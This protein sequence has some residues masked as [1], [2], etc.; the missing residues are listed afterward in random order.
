MRLFLVL[1]IGLMTGA[2]FGW[3]AHRYVAGLPGWGRIAGPVK[4]VAGEVAAMPPADA[5]LAHL[6]RF[7]VLIARVGEDTARY[8]DAIAGLPP[9][10][11]M[12]AIDD[13]QAKMGDSFAASLYKAGIF[14]EMGEAGQAVNQLLAA[15]LLVRTTPQQARLEQA[16]ASATDAAARQLLADH[17]IEALDD[18]YQKITL[19]L[20]ELPEYYLKLGE[21]RIRTGNFDAALAPLSQIQ[22]NP[23]LGARA[24]ALMAQA[25]ASEATH[26][27]TSQSLP[28]QGHGSQFLVQATLDGG[29]KV[30]LLIDT[31]AA[32]TVIDRSLLRSMGYALDGQDEYFLT[33]NGVVAAPVVTVQ[34]L[35]LGDAAIDQLAVGALALDLP[36]NV[37]GLLGMN[38]LRHFD[39]RIDQAKK[40]L[41][42]DQRQ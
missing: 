29:Q 22:N 7:G 9:G 16:L 39:F 10:Q 30:T 3:F 5:E 32:M 20:P 42:L 13:W 4:T 18:L 15:A 19:S 25:E 35:A 33:A 14:R 34:R 1:V 8:I 31:G 36:G 26:V 27:P 17:R 37:Q 6:H 12:A 11:R 41:H 2:A 40:Q 24:R 28:L 38:F 23:E 21:Y